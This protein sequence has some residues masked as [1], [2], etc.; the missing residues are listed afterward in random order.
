MAV[1]IKVKINSMEN[2]LPSY[3]HHMGP[4]LVL[5]LHPPPPLRE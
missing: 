2:A 4:H 1:Y 3:S 5:V